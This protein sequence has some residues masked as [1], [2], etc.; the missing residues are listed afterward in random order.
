LDC[1]TKTKNA[2]YNEKLPSD[3]EKCGRDEETDGE[4]DWNESVQMLQVIGI[5]CRVVLTK[6]VTDRSDTHSYGACF[7]TPY[8]RRV[9][10]ADWSEREGVEDDE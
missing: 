3:V 4:V 6:P 9:D 1:T 10:P 8:F 2:E 7:E 5:M